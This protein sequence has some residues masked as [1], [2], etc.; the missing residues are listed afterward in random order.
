MMNVGATLINSRYWQGRNG[1]RYR[2]KGERRKDVSFAFR[3]SPFVHRASCFVYRVSTYTSITIFIP[4][5]RNRR[6]P[7]VPGGIPPDAPEIGAE[8]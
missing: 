6:E 7:G 4:I 8:D 2:A 5:C 3:L 1:E